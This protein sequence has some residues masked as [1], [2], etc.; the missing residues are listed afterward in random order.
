M[1]AQ[2]E[3]AFAGHVPPD[4]LAL[5]ALRREALLVVIADVVVDHHR[6]LADWQQPAFERGQGYPGIRMHMDGA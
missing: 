6:R 3:D 5:I 2:D 1:V 4:V